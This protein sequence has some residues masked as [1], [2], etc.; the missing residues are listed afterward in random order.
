MICETDLMWWCSLHKCL[1]LKDV[2]SVCDLGVQEL[3]TKQKVVFEQIARSFAQLCGEPDVS[4]DH[5]QS[6]PDM[7]RRLKREIVSLDL[8]GDDVSVLRFD[9]NRDQV[10][11]NLRGHFDLVTNS[12]TTEHV[13]NQANCFEVIH[14][15]T[16][17]GGIMAHAVP[18]A[19]YENHGF[20]KY[21]MKFFTQIAKYND[22]DCLDAWASVDQ[23]DIQSRPGVA[24]FFVDHSGMF[25]NARS[26]DQHPI[27]FYNLKLDEYRSLDACIYVALRKTH[28]R[29]FQFPV[30]LPDDCHTSPPS[31]A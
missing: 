5:C 16:S 31:R 12:G 10:P 20:F 7:W 4:L 11:T 15:L 9:L 24:D 26:S 14:D 13:F 17:T 22:Y 30:D 27:D 25:R 8:V 19:G 6:S 23:N 1:S 21:S 3:H 2:K 28:D 29:T 18:F